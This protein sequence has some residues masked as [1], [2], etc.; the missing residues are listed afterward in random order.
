[1]QNFIFNRWRVNNSTCF[2]R[3]DLRVK[4]KTP[5]LVDK[6]V[7]VRKSLWPL[8]SPPTRIRS[9]NM[10]ADALKV[11]QKARAKMFYNQ[12]LS[13]SSTRPTKPV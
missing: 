5:S 12:N 3:T 4:T 8:Q 11:G 13:I 2:I 10:S 1:M 6:D 7:E 9:M